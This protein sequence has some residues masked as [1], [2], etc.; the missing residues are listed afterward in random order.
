M[1]I[2]PAI[3]GQI[4]KHFNSIVAECEGLSTVRAR[5][6]AL[7]TSALRVLKSKGLPREQA[8]HAARKYLR[9]V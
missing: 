1:T 2:T 7:Y 5:N 4:T 3:K 8:K 6:F 9:T